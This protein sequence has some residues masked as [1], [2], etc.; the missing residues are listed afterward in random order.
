M[1]IKPLSFLSPLIT[2]TPLYL[3]LAV[4]LFLFLTSLLCFQVAHFHLLLQ[5]FIETPQIFH[6]ID[7]PSTEVHSSHPCVED[8]CFS[9]HLLT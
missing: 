7:G 3:P 6:W 2:P 1:Q 8:S 9:S 5:D 4:P